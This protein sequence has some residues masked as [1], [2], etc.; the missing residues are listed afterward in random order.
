[1]ELKI[2]FPITAEFW[3]F[4]ES[5]VPDYYEREDVLHQA[6]LQNFID[7]HDSRIQGITRDEA[8]LLRDRILY[9]L[10]AE[11]IAAF[12]SRP[13]LSALETSPCTSVPKH[14]YQDNVLYKQTENK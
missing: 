6:E 5:T 1:M 2:T 13:S 12:T 4:I 3:D 14:Q 7:G 10:F 9:K 8:L 11:A